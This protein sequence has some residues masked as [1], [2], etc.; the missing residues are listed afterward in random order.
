MFND[1]I[2][3]G[4]RE[5]KK[6]LKKRGHDWRELRRQLKSVADET[7]ELKEARKALRRFALTGKF[8]DTLSKEAGF[9][10]KSKKDTQSLVRDALRVGNEDES[11]V[12]CEER[13]GD[14]SE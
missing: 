7:A 4:V 14:I 1:R 2:T 11:I 6:R 13:H 12:W 5:Q 9:L 8:P 10:L 3:N